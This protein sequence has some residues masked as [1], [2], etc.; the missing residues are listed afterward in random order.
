MPLWR[1]RVALPDDP[2]SQEALRTAVAAYPAE[3]VRV[4]SMDPGGADLTGNVVVELRDDG[5]L[6]DLLHALHE[7]SPHVFVSRVNPPEASAPQAAA[8]VRHFQH[9]LGAYS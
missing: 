7:I 3:R 8:R 9:R 2:R 5:P 4:E 6:G 1:I